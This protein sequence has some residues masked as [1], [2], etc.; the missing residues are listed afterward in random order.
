LFYRFAF[1]SRIPR[2]H[3]GGDAV[4]DAFDCA[5]DVYANA[6]ACLMACKGVVANATVVYLPN[7]R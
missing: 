5:L 3:G 6:T 7:L 1:V 4:G 2:F